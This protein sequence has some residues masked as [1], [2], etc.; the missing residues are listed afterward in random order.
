MITF[1]QLLLNKIV[2]PTYIM[3]HK[4]GLLYHSFAIIRYY[5]FQYCQT[6]SLVSY[7]HDIFI[8]IFQLLK[9]NIVQL[10][11]GHLKMSSMD[12]A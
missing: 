6:D 9:L 5:L 10:F 1:A 8:S 7:R 2:V 4:I 12:F 11:K 3:S